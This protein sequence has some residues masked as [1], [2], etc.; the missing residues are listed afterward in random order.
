MAGLG[1]RSGLVR[2]R[3]GTVRHRRSRLVVTAAVDRVR[4]ARSIAAAGSRATR[5]SQIQHPSS[6]PLNP[7]TRRQREEVVRD[8][9][10]LADQAGEL[11]PAAVV[12]AARPE[13][14]PIHPALEWHDAIAAE[15]HR[16]VQARGIIRRVHVVAAPPK[17]DGSPIAVRVIVRPL[18]T[19][20]AALEET[21]APAD[22]VPE[23]R[24]LESFRREVAL[25]YERFSHLSELR[26][27]LEELQE[28]LT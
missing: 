19:V 9:A 28:R 4:I 7:L 15:R 3:F 12:E 11:T 18:R 8:L 23:T 21:E 20:A 22:A 17:G 2:A 10:R 1:S 14:S 6:G 24:Y 13:D 5:V 25:L 27:L 16:A 26:P